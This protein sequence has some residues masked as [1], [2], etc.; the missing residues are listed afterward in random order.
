[1]PANLP[2]GPATVTLL[3]GETALAVAAIRLARLSP[4]IFTANASGE[5]APAGLALYVNRAGGQR[6]VNLFER[7]TG[8]LRFEPAA[9]NVGNAEEDVYLLLFGTGFRAAPA[10]RVLVTAG[11]QAIP[12]QASQA[13]GGARWKDV[14]SSGDGLKADSRAR[15]PM[16]WKF[17]IRG[18]ICGQKERRCQSRGGE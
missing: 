5:G 10:N 6:Y 2:D 8:S 16:R 15:G 14:M 17:M 9:L 11:G 12:I 18:R 13:Q 1:M 7:F 4:G 3:R